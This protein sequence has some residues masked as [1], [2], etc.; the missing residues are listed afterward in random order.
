[1]S[2]FSRVYIPYIFGGRGGD[3]ENQK[4]F[5]TLLTFWPDFYDFHE[6][7]SECVWFVYTHKNVDIYGRPLSHCNTRQFSTKKNQKNH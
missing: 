1:M 6:D 7:F 2:I 4:Y 3:C 5:C